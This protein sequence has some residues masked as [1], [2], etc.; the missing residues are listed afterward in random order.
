MHLLRTL[1]WLLLLCGAASSAA[2][3]GKSE[4]GSSE[5]KAALE[6]QFSLDPVELEASAELHQARQ[7][8]DRAE[9]SACVALLEAFLDEHPQ[10]ARLPDALFMKAEALIQLKRYADAR[11][12]FAQLLNRHPNKTQ[13]VHAR[14]RI[15]E[16]AMLSGD[17]PLARQLLEKFRADYPVHELNAY[18]IPYLAET[19]GR[20]GDAQK[21]LGLYTESLRQYPAGPL[22][23]ESQL[24]LGILHYQEKNYQAAREIL[25]ELAEAS[26]RSAV[27]YW[28]AQYWL[29]MTEFRLGQL[30]PAAK[31]FLEFSEAQ[32]DD[33]LAAAATY[34]AAA[35]FRRS[36]RPQRAADLFQQL[37]ERWPDSEFAS[38]SGLVEMQLAHQ[39]GNTDRAIQLYDQLRLSEDRTIKEAAARHAVEMLLANQ[40]F[41]EARGIVQPLVETP[42]SLIQ[43]QARNDHYK[44]L[45]LLA[46]AERGLSRFNRANQLLSRIRLGELPPGLAE[47]VLLARVETFNAAKDF[48]SALEQ[49]FHYE[50]RFPSGR[51][52][53]AVRSQMVIALAALGRREEAVLK[54][55]QLQGDKAPPIELARAARQLGEACYEAGDLQRAREVFVVLEAVHQSDEDLAQAISGLAWIELKQANREAAK[56]RFEEFLARYP[57]SPSAP[58]VRLAHAMNL[59][60]TGHP[61]QAIEAL[62]YFEKLPPSQPVRARGLYQLADLLYENRQLSRGL[63]VVERLLKEH[64]QFEHRDAAL[65]L[66]GTIQ[67]LQRKATAN[68]A[69]TEIVEEHRTSKFWS[70]SLFRLA[71]SAA[72]ESPDQAN[73]YLTKLISAERDRKVLPHALYMK[74]RIESEAK[75]WPAARETLRQLLRQF[76]DSPLVPVARYGVAESFYQQQQFEHALELFELLD[77]RNEFRPEQ[78]WGAMVQLRR[79][80]LYVWKN[81]PVGAIRIAD[82]I[83]ADFPDFSLQR[84]VDYLIARAHASRGEFSKA[85]EYYAKIIQADKNTES[86]L[87]AMA[88]WMTGE[89]YFHQ[90]KYILAIKT[91]E[92]LASDTAFPKWQAA[93][94]LQIGKCYELSNNLEQAHQAYSRVVDR[95]PDSDSAEEAEYRLS[96][97]E[98]AP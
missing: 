63:R 70:D 52:L 26:Q 81:D 78:T 89:T 44:D 83:Q 90:K 50:S 21:A 47:K 60:E 87:A 79:A 76:P 42:R 29:A 71:E 95:F 51:L 40:R 82:R 62:T 59:A 94:Y 58:E 16:S 31:R 84:E 22:A 68:A 64:P 41:A 45:F 88:K 14:F 6:L 80:Q 53:S 8:Y 15:A 7:H 33:K 69:F 30:G 32:P 43:P 37:R 77:Q 2:E 72:R 3:E 98:Y 49:A 24:R 57:E 34:H 27:G 54:F 92:A 93:S 19:L 75:N 5:P 12:D 86:E 65:Y 97:L 38:R 73:Q 17:L 28:K 1:L 25:F 46:L 11:S 61:D 10:D 39:L 20:L 96:V 48:G 55:R 67:R 23:R 85:R 74:G 9:W 35:A 4:T 13:R 66:S 56:A 18:V 91:F 36:D